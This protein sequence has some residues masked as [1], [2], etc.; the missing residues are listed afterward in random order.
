MMRTTIL[1][2]ALAAVLSTG[3]PELRAQTLATDDPVLTEIWRQAMYRSQIPMLAQALLD[4]I[5]PRLTASPGMERA[6]AWAVGKLGGW[7]YDAR[8]EEYGTWLGWDRGV[9]HVDLVAPR[10]RSLEGRILAWSPGTGGEPVEGEVVALPPIGRPGDFAA[11]LPYVQGRFVMV[12]FP[13]MSCRTDEQWKEFAQEGSFERMDQARTTARDAWNA[14]LAATGSED[15]RRRDVHRALERA[16]AL[17]IVTSLWPGSYGTTRVFNSYTREIPTF[18]LSCEDYGLVYRL[19]ANGQ[20]PRLRLT[21]EAEFLGEVPVFNVLASIPGSE[22]PD[23]YVMLSAHF[24]SWEGGS[25][26]TDNGTG[27]VLMMEAARIL[28]EVYPN[29]KRTILIGLW[30]GEEQGLNGSRAFVEDHPEVVAGL[31]ALFNQD[32][33]TGRVVSMSASGL[34]D[35]G[36]HLG[37]WLSRVPSEVTR[38]IDLQFPGTPSSGGTDHASFVCAPAP[39]FGLGA[40]SWDYGTHTWHTHRD[41]FDKLVFD[42]LKNNAVLVASLVYLASEDPER[43]SREQRSVLPPAR[44]GQPTEWPVCQP[45]TRASGE[46]PRM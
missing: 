41:T 14:S 39:G 10:V 17:G 37:R 46:S 34:V 32:N 19:A 6:Q 23:E 11:F 40:L 5:G 29:P 7:G 1:A 13:E 15:P 35:A 26:A 31:Q 22:L 44:N 43:V 20:S 4:S 21:A 8:T 18:E 33:G 30:S 27:S 36:A 9:S 24:D 25:G 3:A 2:A 38:Y 12:S 16:G 42:D 28:R 45:A